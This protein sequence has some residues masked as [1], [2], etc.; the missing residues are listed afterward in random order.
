MLKAEPGSLHFLMLCSS[1]S[2]VFNSSIVRGPLNWFTKRLSNV[3]HQGYDRST[4]KKNN[5]GGLPDQ[6][7]PFFPQRGRVFVEVWHL[8][9]N[10]LRNRFG[11]CKVSS[12]PAIAANNYMIWLIP[13]NFQFVNL[14]YLI[15]GRSKW[16]SGSLNTHRLGKYVLHNKSFLYRGEVT[17]STWHLN[18]NLNSRP[19]SKSYFPLCSARFQN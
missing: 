16:K 14:K 17:R 10:C 15:F 2:R 3:S 11:T 6:H 7:K 4:S 12:Q 1:S 8:I 18:N 19:Y 13:F 5:T 9:L